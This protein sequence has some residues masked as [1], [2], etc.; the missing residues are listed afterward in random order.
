ME[1]AWA[2][3]APGETR[4]HFFSDGCAVFNP[5]RWETHVIDLLVGTLIEALLEG[6]KSVPELVAIALDASDLPVEE[7]A[8]FV[9]ATLV[10]L[11]GLDLV[12]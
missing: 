7:G 10:Q 4:L 6:P 5:I 9:E 1:R 3:A 8:L 12:A 11:S 2:L